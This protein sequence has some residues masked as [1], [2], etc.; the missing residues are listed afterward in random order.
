MARILYGVQGGGLGHATR[1][2]T[3]IN[4][5]KR[6]HE[7]HVCAGLKAYDL[8]RRHY[9]NDITRVSC[10]ELSYGDLCIRPVKSV[11]DYIKQYPALRS[12]IRAIREFAKDWKPDVVITDLEPIVAQVAYDLHV[13]LI[14]FGNHHILTNV[15]SSSPKGYA[16]T[17]AMATIVTKGYVPRADRYIITGFFSGEP[18]KPGTF[19][20]PPCVQPEIVNAKQRKGD[21]VFVYQTSHSYT[22]ILPVL[23]SMKDQDFI[24]YHPGPEWIDN[25]V[26]MKPLFGKDYFDDL[27]SC[28]AV[29][30]NGGLSLISEA[31]Y[32]KKPVLAIPLHLQYEQILNAHEVDRRGYGMVS[33]HLSREVIGEFLSK[34]SE[35]RR[36]LASYTQDGNGVLLSTLRNVIQE[37]TRGSK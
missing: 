29:I 9:P 28:K 24:V 13:P 30:T 5:L 7:V 27:A 26:T 22:S 3:L 37:L 21:R 12:S 36:N 10:V 17:K 35:Y 16:V 2:I 18:K 20:V 25:N 6:D 15:R 11:L 19:L 1:G 23:K 33:Q 4:E 32:L 8:L 14:A 31:V 34:E